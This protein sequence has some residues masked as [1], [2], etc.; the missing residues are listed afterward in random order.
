M[1]SSSGAEIDLMV[2]LSSPLSESFGFPFTISAVNTTSAAVNGT[3]SL[4]VRPLRTLKRQCV[5]VSSSDSGMVAAR[6]GYC[7]PLTVSISH[8]LL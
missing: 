1:V 7:V 5:F 3:P 4:Q 2:L 6:S 8:R